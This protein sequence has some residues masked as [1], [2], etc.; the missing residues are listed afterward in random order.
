MTEER[1]IRTEAVGEAD[2]SS[3]LQVAVPAGRA[4][5]PLPFPSSCSCSC[6]RAPKVGINDVAKPHLHLCPTTN[7]GFSVS[8]SRCVPR[9]PYVE[10]VSAFCR[11]LP[12]VLVCQSPF[13]CVSRSLLACNPIAHLVC[14]LL[15]EWSDAMGSQSLLHFAVMCKY[16]VRWG[17]S[18]VSGP[19]PL[20][21]TAAIS[22]C[23]SNR[24]RVRQRYAPTGGGNNGLR[25][26]KNHP[27]RYR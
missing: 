25:H 19:S 7:S 10:S 6:L 3:T 17:S 5:T 24:A 4:A 1:L 12:K 11:L 27:T 23:Q 16:A 20:L 18:Q 13:S 22:N 15:H 26:R 8:P 14:P 2:E 21:S 9:L